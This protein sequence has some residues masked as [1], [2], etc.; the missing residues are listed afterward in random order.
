MCAG[1]VVVGSEAKQAATP[2]LRRMTCMHLEKATRRAAASEGQ[3]G[4]PNTVTLAA[5]GD[6]SA[7]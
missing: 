6:L 1:C 7:T 2:R 5:S 4:D 3:L